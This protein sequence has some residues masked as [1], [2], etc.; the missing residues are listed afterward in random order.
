MASI[1]KSITVVGEFNFVKGGKLRKFELFFGG[2]VT[3]AI[4]T[5]DDV[6]HIL[7]KCDDVSYE[8]GVIHVKAGALSIQ[9][10]SLE[11]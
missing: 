7:D 5:E 6:Y 1:R 8:L 4:M 2:A 3:P 9:I 11:D 10:Y